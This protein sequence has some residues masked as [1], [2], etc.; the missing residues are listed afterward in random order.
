MSLFDRIHKEYV[1]IIRT[2]EAIRANEN[3]Y[4]IG[5]T[6]D[7]IKKRLRG[8]SFY[9]SILTLAVNNAPFVEKKL[10]ELLPSKYTVNNHYGKEYFNVDNINDFIKDFFEI[11][12]T[13][14]LSKG[15]DGIKP[16]A[17]LNMN[18]KTDKVIDTEEKVPLNLILPNV[19]NNHKQINVTINNILPSNTETVV[20]NTNIINED[21]LN[22]DN[23]TCKRCGFKF[24][25]KYL[26]IR[27]LKNRKPCN[28][29]LSNTSI[30][31]LKNI[32]NNSSLTI[33]KEDK[34]YYK[35]K[36]CKIMFPHRSGKSVHQ[37]KCKEFYLKK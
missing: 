10:L 37:K 31:D 29:V 25:F 14:I 34:K 12:T 2:R 32:V 28:T 17:N 6:V 7:T 5:M 36:Y 20:N 9:E 30:E 15:G 16:D 18:I 35:C 4:K 3:V 27:H 21:L 23:T 26:L 1:Y 8:Y 24:K 33:I 11:S 13:N 22:I 19:G